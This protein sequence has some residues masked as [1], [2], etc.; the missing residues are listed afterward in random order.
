MAETT[1]NENGLLIGMAVLPSQ[2]SHCE[3]RKEVAFSCL[4]S[5]VIGNLTKGQSFGEVSVMKKI[6]ATCSVVSSSPIELGIIKPEKL[7]DLDDITKHL[8]TQTSSAILKDMSKEKIH[9]EF[10]QQELNREWIEYKM[11]LVKQVV[12]ATGRANKL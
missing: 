11:K 9:E 2:Y 6:P 7:Y 12:T 1:C 8:L 3:R 5:V 10:V 4:Y